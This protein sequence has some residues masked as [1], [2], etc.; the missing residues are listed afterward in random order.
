M[1]YNEFLA[2][3]IK[4]VLKE[5]TVPFTEK[6]MMGGLTFM[7]DDKMCVGIV[8]DSLMARIDPE[9]YD[10]DTDLEYWIDLALEYNP[11]ARSS[12]KKT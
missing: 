4:L 8:K 3:R 7:I 2:E 12:K 9:G 6:A 1:A 10:L 5:K 11:K